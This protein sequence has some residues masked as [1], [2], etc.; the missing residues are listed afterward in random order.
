[1]SQQTYDYPAS[2]D[3]NA[4]LGAA[5]EAFQDN[6]KENKAA[7]DELIQ[8]N[9]APGVQST[10]AASQDKLDAQVKVMAAAL[11]IADGILANSKAY[12]EAN[13]GDVD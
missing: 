5:I 10:M 1:M 12:H 8:E 11:E 2:K 13:G 3:A 7:I 6:V 9:T 4:K